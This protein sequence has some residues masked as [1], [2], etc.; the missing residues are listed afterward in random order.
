M[1]RNWGKGGFV[2]KAG[3][4][5]LL[6]LI[7]IFLTSLTIIAITGDSA[8]Y[9][10]TSKFDSF[11]GNV[12]SPS[13]NNRFIGGSQPAGNYTSSSYGGRFGV[14]DE[15]QDSAVNITYPLQS[16]EISRGGG[17]ISNEDDSGLVSD[18]LNI[19]LR[20]YQ[21]GTTA[22]FNNVNVSFYFNSSYL[23]SNLTNASGHAV[24][25]YDKTSKAAGNYPIFVNYSSLVYNNVINTSQINIS[26]NVFNIPNEQGNK[27]VANQYVWNQTAIL[28]FNITKTNSSGTYFYDPQNITANATDTAEKPYP[29]SLYISGYRVYRTAVGQYQT[30]VL[31]NQTAL[32]AGGYTLT[33][34]R[35]SIYV[36]DDNWSSFIAS[37]RHSDV[38]LA[39]GPIC[40]N[41][42]L[43][44]GEGCD[45]SNIISGD[46]CSSA[47]AVEGNAGQEP[48]PTCTNDCTLGSTETVCVTGST[49]R[50]RACGNYDSDTCSEW[51]GE[52][53]S[54]CGNNYICQNAVC[55]PA[56]CDSWQCGDWSQCATGTQIRT[57]VNTN[58]SCNLA[59]KTESRACAICAESWQC[60]W[61][62]CEEGEAYSYAYDCNDVNHCGTQQNIPSKINCEDRGEINETYTPSEE[63]ESCSPKWKCGNYSECK[64]KLNPDNLLK[65][66]TS[67]GGYQE[68]ICM[69]TTFC[70]RNKTERKE[71]DVSIPIIAKKT[72]WCSEDYVELFEQKSGD[73][74]GRV[75]KTEFENIKELSRIDIFFVTTKFAGY[76]DYC[77]NLIK[78]EDE[79]GVDCGGPNCPTCIQKVVFF[80]WLFWLIIIL[81]ITLAILIFKVYSGKRKEERIKAAR[82]RKM[83][84]FLKLLISKFRMREREEK[85]IEMRIGRLLLNVLLWPFRLIAKLFRYKIKLERGREPAHR[86]AYR[87]T[88]PR[89]GLFRRIAKAFK[90]ARREERKIAGKP[91]IITT[92]K[93]RLRSRLMRRL[94]G[95]R[96]E[97]YYGVSKVE[98]ELGKAE[99]EPGKIVK[100]IKRFVAAYKAKRVVRKEKRK[101]GRHLRAIQ[102]EFRRK[103]KVER[104]AAEKL[105]RTGNKIRRKERRKGIRKL[106]GEI[107]RKRMINLMSKLRLWKKEGYY[108]TAHLETELKKLKEER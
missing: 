87:E 9:N 11:A 91:I 72:S 96:R 79:T 62:E 33:N 22:G 53:Y 105:I 95:L 107:R 63:G 68:R 5:I 14:L 60:G 41:S 104:R 65:G 32:A 101:E 47:C 93:E 23:G 34:I 71:C 49:L 24:W 54:D 2:N 3:F 6:A 1:K 16:Q 78:D 18:I 25:G 38:G 19:K 44:S 39:N 103:I 84:E 37:A 31:L 85:V 64:V 58:P 81:W 86:E 100:G 55:A 73:L 51:G 46:G 13:F 43:E 42:L 97:G 102:K 29:E 90:P 27:G 56:V 82:K 59:D 57:C 92:P 108:G 52:S 48:A 45:D 88:V 106:K 61:T 28:Y 36:S 70:A 15:L 94:R 77:Y 83:R 76:C 75:K 50:T 21:N 66:E 67:F 17:V 80:D 30:R 98:R 99:K 26:L 8:S 20:V 40:G 7:F 10:V 74:V 35:W 4:V 69:D 12:S 89:G